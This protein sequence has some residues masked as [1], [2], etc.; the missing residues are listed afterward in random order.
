VT[1]ADAPASIVLGRRGRSR[2]WGRH[3]DSP[4]VSGWLDLSSDAV[5]RRGV[6]WRARCRRSPHAARYLE[7]AGAARELA[8]DRT[9]VL[10]E[11]G[12]PLESLQPGLPL[13]RDGTD[14][15]RHLFACAA[16]GRRYVLWA[17]TYTATVP[18]TKHRW[19]G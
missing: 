9:I 15:I 13:P 3:S 2:V 6:R 17:D 4:C 18:G 16:C 5:S 1:L 10:V 14:S 8:A 12:V 7:L 19:L 11:G